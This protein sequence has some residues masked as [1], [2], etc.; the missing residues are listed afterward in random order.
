MCQY[1]LMLSANAEGGVWG[2]VGSLFEDGVSRAIMCARTLAGWE[3]GRRG[4]I[5]RGVRRKRHTFN[6]NSKSFE[7]DRLMRAVGHLLNWVFLFEKSTQNTA[8][9]GTGSA[10]VL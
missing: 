6:A 4:R 9:V 1:A 8:G 10:G 5:G 2:E 7:I 3:P